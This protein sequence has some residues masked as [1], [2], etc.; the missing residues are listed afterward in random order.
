MNDPPTPRCD[1]SWTDIII[2]LTILAYRYEGLRVDDFE[3]DVLTLLRSDFE[4]EVGPYKLRK[5]S[6]LYEQWVEAAGGTIKG[7]TGAAKGGAARNAGAPAAAAPPE[8]EAEDAEDIVVPLWLLKQSNETQ[9]SKLFALLRRL[10]AVIH[11]Y[12][13]QIVFP[14]FMQHQALKLSSSGQELGGSMLFN[15]SR[16]GFS[17]TPSDLLPLD[18]GR[19]A[20]GYSRRHSPSTQPVESAP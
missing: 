9:M 12:L 19:C 20:R 1:A 6:I 11:S 8:E 4:K 13:E 14:S 15:A 10:P 18:L 17:G 16:I 2:G 3:Q 5:S 7:S